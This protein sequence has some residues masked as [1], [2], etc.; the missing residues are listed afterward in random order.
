[1]N[2]VRGIRLAI[3]RQLAARPLFRPLRSGYA[4]RGYVSVVALLFLSSIGAG[5]LQPFIAADAYR[6]DSAGRAVLPD[7]NKEFADVMKFDPKQQLYNFNEGYSAASASE[8]GGGPRY[9]AVFNEDPV[10]GITATDSMNNV[11]FTMV[12]EFG[13]G[14]AERDSNQILYPLKDTRGFL[15]YT[16][17]V[18]S[19]K[20]DILLAQFSGDKVRYDYELKLGDSM[21]ARL[22]KSGAIGIY[23]GDSPITGA[24]STG[25]AQDQAL[26]QKARQHMKKTKLLFTIPAPEVVESGKKVSQVKAHYELTDGNKLHLVA[27]HLKGASYPLAIDPSVYISSAQKLMRGNN[28]TNI[29]FDTSNNLIEKGKLSGG[30][31]NSWINTL[32]LP[33]NLWNQGTAVAGGYIYT[34]GGMSN[35][36][37]VSTVYWAQLD[38]TSNA[39][40]SPTPGTSTACPSW[41]NNPVYNLPVALSG[42]QVVAYSGYL[43]VFGGS[44][45][46]SG[47]NTLSN[48]V[49]IAKI[50]AN[51]EPQLW[52]PTDTNQANWVYWYQAANMTTAKDCFGAAAYNNRM[53]LVGGRTTYNGSGSGAATNIIEEA[54]ISPNG[55]LGSW[56]TTG[57]L[58]LPSVRHSF[59]LQIYNDRLYVIGGNSGGVIQN[60]VQYARINNDGTMAGPWVTTTNML[61]PRFSN[62]GNFAMITNGYLYV[63]GGCSGVI[64]TGDWCSTSGLSTDRDIELASI[65][66]DGSVTAWTAI[67][68]ITYQRSSY[69]FMAWRQT[70]YGIGGC[71]APNE[72]TGMC[73]T[74][75]NVSDYG[76]INADGD[77]ST[78]NNSVASGTAPCSGTTPTNCN[79]PPA[80]ASAGQI[81]NMA[82]GVALNNGYIYLFGGCTSVTAT[83]NCYNHNT[84]AMSPNTAYAA[85]AVDG[86]I[87]SPATCSGTMVGTWCVDSTNQ[88]NPSTGMG[89]MATTVFNNTVYIIGGTDGASWSATIYRNTFN[90]NGSLAGAWSSQAFNS[91]GLGIARGFSYAYSRANPASAGTDPGVMWVIGGCNNGT[92]SNGIPCTS[93]YNYVYKCYITT[94]GAIDTTNLC[95]TTGQIQLDSENN[96]AGAGLAAMAG[97][98]YAGYMYLMGGQSPNETTRGEVMYAQIDNNNDIV[99]AP[100]GAGK[101][102]FSPNQISPARQ[103]NAAFGYNG[104]LYSLAG[105]SGTTSLNDVLYAKINVNDGS[106]GT[107]TTSQVTV[108]PRWGLMSVVSNG[109]VYAMGGCSSGSAPS[110]CTA[111]TQA[112]QTFQLYNNY[113]GTPAGYNTIN[114]PGVDRIGGSSVVLNGYLYFAGGCSDM[115]CTTPTNTVYYAQLGADGSVGAF[116]AAANALPGATAWGKLVASGGTLYYLGG[117][118]AT[119]TAQSAVYYSTPTGGVPAAWGT[120][121]NGL[122]GAL[123]EIGATVWD[124]QI[125]VT[126]GVT[127]GARQTS[128]YISPTLSQGGDITSA[129]TSGTGFN[130]ARSGAT[131]I[132]Y[133]NTLY[134]IGGSDGTNYLNDVQYIKINSDGT[135][136]SSGWT[137]STSLPQR[138]YQA[139]G[140]ASNGYMYV[141]GGRGTS[142]TCTNNTYISSISANTPIANG[143]NPTGIGD[144][145]QTNVVYTGGRYGEAVANDQG[146]AYIIGGGCNGTFVAAGNRGYYTTMQSQ[147]AVAKYSRAIDT[148][149][150]VTPTKWLI[151]GLD[152]DVGARWQLKYRSSTS[153]TNAWGRETTYGTV[154]LGTPD[155]FYPLDS[156][157]TNTNTARYYYFN[158]YIDSSK[159]F[160]YP[161]DISRGP[162]IKDL[163][164]FFISDPSK[165]LRH[166]ATFTSGQLQPLDTPF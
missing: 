120:A 80:G 68:G 133:A 14:M 152:N 109:F 108:N 25:S 43:Y 59:G 58:T 130:I 12:P 6:L 138:V 55:L 113:S 11:D 111:M 73:T 136:S 62:G 86:S 160:G 125:Y 124:N 71:T 150:D 100:G 123:S 106:I 60:T 81:G 23:G 155:N 7:Q 97:T 64:G 45:G 37:R 134:V 34:V 36:A 9:S 39:I 119:G 26:L 122:P 69:G 112:V 157:G 50:G 158:L 18:A 127:G 151:N 2:T 95:T 28:E 88:I 31:F 114:N 137:Y 159:A 4:Y 142:T 132:S 27:E 32:T 105:Y 104:Y 162:T 33:V 76:P 83:S 24:V 84:G 149:S 21:E 65:N 116:T 56:T 98:V 70:L 117:Q 20:E 121:T 49:Y 75:T 41:C 163:S 30:R 53:Y 92:K 57:M 3:L 87:V 77:V 47:V 96:G 141:F 115:A 94:S 156:N 5:I 17:Q 8:T 131:T 107:F 1:M 128:V 46:A 126:G 144:W 61:N 52:H 38:P 91:I 118:D 16:A 79:I 44:T 154:T 140:Y 85:L 82:D 99:A 145:S 161:D 103:R 13:L 93:F 89:A 42:M 67:T 146:R 72:T 101:W 139:D 147:P 148:S 54:D 165:R 110:A 19:V 15:V 29:D 153:A 143:N 66:A 102:I 10:K 40:T 164:L 129:W 35:N 22:Q 51:G 78:T 90:T 74:E 63:A 166:G 135:L 48:A